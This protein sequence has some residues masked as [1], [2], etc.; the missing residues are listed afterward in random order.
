MVGQTIRG[1]KDVSRQ[2]TLR[3]IIG[4]L[5]VLGL[6][7]VYLF[8][9]TDVAGIFGADPSNISRFIINR[10]VRFLLNDL[11][12]IGV[13]YALFVERKYLVFSLWV[14]LAGVVLFLLP[15]FIL[16]LNFPSYNGPLINYLHRLIL[17][18]TL[19][20]LLIP[21]FYYQR[22]LGGKGEIRE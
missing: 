7:G 2:T 11:F 16:K 15:Y 12:A 8:Q 22:G 19:L 4:A 14:Q 5:S 21:A 1:F 13:I 9:R 10:T 6:V 18:P 17:N 3:I 20:L